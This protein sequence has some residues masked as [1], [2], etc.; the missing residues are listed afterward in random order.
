MELAHEVTVTRAAELKLAYR[1]LLS[2]G[3]GFKRS[4]SKDSGREQYSRTPCCVFEVKRKRA[5]TRKAD[6]VRRLPRYLYV[7][8]DAGKGRELCAVP[9]DVRVTADFGRPHPHG[10]TGWDFGIAVGP[11]GA[12]TG[13]GGAVAAVLR[14][15]GAPQSSYGLSC[16]HVLGLSLEVQPDIASG[17]VVHAGGADLDGVRIGVTTPARG[18]LV[19]TPRP[20]FDAQLLLIEQQEALRPCTS[21]FTLNPLNPFVTGPAGIPAAFYVASPRNGPGGK[22]LVV[23]VEFRDTPFMRPMP[24]TLPNGTTLSVAHTLVL[25]AE[26]LS[27]G[28][29]GGDSGSPA[30]SS[31]T[32]GTFVGMYLGG[33]GRHCYFIPAWQLMTAANYGL[34]ATEQLALAW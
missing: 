34:P 25:H 7:F 18:P 6:A 15:S 28:L 11:P 1:D 8:F 3:F 31:P 16:R 19:S 32:G 10:G 14:R 20:S 9:T 24:Y 23:R 30:F 4:R 33:D 2:V 13:E 5:L 21:G 29:M 22:R 12:A 17:C 27:D 26:A